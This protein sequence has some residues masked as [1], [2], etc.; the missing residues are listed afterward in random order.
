MKLIL[1]QTVENLGESGTVV[2]VKPGYAR[3]YLLPQGL[4]YE[5]SE[6]NLRKIEEEQAKAEERS[7]RDY[8][9]ARRRASQL[10][11]AALTFQEQA[12]DEG[13]LYGSVSA[14]DIA[15]G[16][17]AQELDFEVERKH[18]DLAD[19]I[20]EVGEYQVRVVLHEEVELEIPV[21]VE[22]ADD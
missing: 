3:N 15:E 8:L 13:K 9:E 21:Q 4:A 2:D 22:R 17:N 7:R 16:L 20:K 18:V 10:E 5:A 6:A 12:S 11:G 14:V 19:P 1:K